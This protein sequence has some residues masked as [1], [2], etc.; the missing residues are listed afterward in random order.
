MECTVDVEKK[1]AE[2][3]DDEKAFELDR[4]LNMSKQYEN[5]DNNVENDDKTEDIKKTKNNNNKTT[6]DKKKKKRK[7][8]KGNRCDLSDCDVTLGIMAYT[9]KCR[10][11][12]CAQHR[13]HDEHSCTYDYKKDEQMKL[14]NSNPVI[15]GDKVE[16]F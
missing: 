13:Y 1:E 15:V 6:N 10:R 3:N 9:C 12:F 7:K 2:V 4:Q 16:K 8:I 14:V 5:K 11:N